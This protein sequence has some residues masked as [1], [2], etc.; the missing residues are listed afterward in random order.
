MTIVNTMVMEDKSMTKTTAMRAGRCSECGAH[1]VAWKR[2]N[3]KAR[4]LRLLAM[5]DHLK[6]LHGLR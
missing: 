2:K 4:L 6:T 1:V 5:A 3:V